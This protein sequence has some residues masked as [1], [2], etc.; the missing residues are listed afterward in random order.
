VSDDILTQG[1]ILYAGVGNLLRSD[2]GVG[3]YIAE[4]IKSLSVNAGENSETIYFETLKHKPDKVIIFDACDFSGKPGEWRFIDPQ[5]IDDMS[6]ST[7][8]MPLNLVC[9]LIK[10]DTGAEVYL[11][12]IQPCS[13]EPG[14][15]L[16][17]AVKKTAD[18][19]IAEI[20]G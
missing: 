1:K 20:C 18:L 4:K 10:E 14:T 9:R 19:L 12:G 13:L 2:D 15:E 6:L 11:A 3:C 17:P 5:F 7:H 16:S 8:K